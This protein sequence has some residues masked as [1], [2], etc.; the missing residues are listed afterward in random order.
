MHSQQALPIKNFKSY[1]CTS[2]FSQQIPCQYFTNHFHRR[3][4]SHLSAAVNQGTAYQRGMVDSHKDCENTVI[5][6]VGS[7]LGSRLA[8]EKIGDGHSSRTDSGVKHR[9]NAAISSTPPKKRP[10]KENNSKRRGK[11]KEKF[12]DAQYK[13]INAIR[14]SCKRNDSAAA[15]AAFRR[16]RSE[17]LPLPVDV[18]N[19]M[20]YMAADGENWANMTREACKMGANEQEDTGA[21]ENSQNVREEANSKPDIA[22]Y[23]AEIL[24]YIEKNNIEISEMVYT[25]QA[26]LAAA[27]GDPD[28]AFTFIRE[29]L[30]KGFKPRLRLFHPALVGYA[31]KGRPEAAR[32]VDNALT[33]SGLDLHE[34]EF[35]LLLEACAKG[36]TFEQ[37]V[38]VLARVGQELT[39]LKE[40]TVAHV[41]AF[42]KSDRAKG[43]LGYG[44]REDKTSWE[45][46]RVKVDKDGYCN[47]AEGKLAFIDLND[48]EW[49]AFAE[50][51]KNL[52]LKQENTQS[53]FDKFLD[54]LERHRP[55][56][57]IVIDGANVALFGQN[58][59]GGYFRFGQI[60]GMV[61]Q[62]EQQFPGQKIL[63]ILHHGRTVSKEAR[64]PA[65][66]NLLQDLRDRKR[67]FSTPVG[68]NDDWYWLYASILAGKNGML[69]SNDE[70]RD[71]IFQ[72]VA[73]KYFLKWKE[74]H[75]IRYGFEMKPRIGRVPRLIYPKPYTSCTQ[76][77]ENGS[78]MAPIGDGEEWLCCKPV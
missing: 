62:I 68:S 69:I 55:Y 8:S 5:E 35:A 42:F 64:D 57:D 24:E 39:Y 10:R 11:R 44:K 16:A 45:V 58:Y 70:M 61:K 33:G 27:Q 71:H 12:S 41:E 7:R 15:L 40:S 26:R 19:S 28:K 54:W 32:V 76:E 75:L 38:G 30:E 66:A 46:K 3:L 4:I 29:A 22:S 72:L 31:A 1:K 34:Y 47:F 2:G 9:N 20:M 77:L 78:W 17:E 48:D 52:A 56:P 49:I 50:G 59:I 74:R 36:G 14:Q 43:G 37:F 6:T 65:A 18:L 60:R 73:P 21:D 53:N 13:Y 25:A 63:L 67:F 51:V 23:G